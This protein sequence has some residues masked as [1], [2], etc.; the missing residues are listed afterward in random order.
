M[1][2]RS[3]HLTGRMQSFSHYHIDGVMAAALP[4]TDWK[5]LH[6][7]RPTFLYKLCGHASPFTLDIE[8]SVCYNEHRTS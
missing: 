7:L 8:V 6:S 2:D 5:C 1:I 3:V 4:T